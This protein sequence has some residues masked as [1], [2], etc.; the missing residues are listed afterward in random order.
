MHGAMHGLADGLIRQRVSDVNEVEALEKGDRPQARR[1][2]SRSRDRTTSVS[3]RRATADGLRGR[4]SMPGDPTARIDGE[5]YPRRHGDRRRARCARPAGTEVDLDGDP[6]NALNRTRYGH[7]A[8]GP[9]GEGREVGASAAGNR[10][11][12]GSRNRQEHPGINQERDCRGDQGR[13]QE[14]DHRPARGPRSGEVEA[15]L[16]GGACSS[17]AACWCTRQDRG[18][19]KEA[20]LGRARRWRHH[21]PP[22]VADRQRHVE[23]CRSV[24]GGIGP[25]KRATLVG[26][27]TLGRAAVRNSS[28]FQMAAVDARPT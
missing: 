28:A 13:R 20:V 25:A 14:R 23:W 12:R 10:L 26:E 24:R 9:A 1:P 11:S 15:G 4:L 22:G 3:S 16:G 6:W 17:R 21:R 5:L 7:C 2:A 18:K 19:D 8:R 27:R